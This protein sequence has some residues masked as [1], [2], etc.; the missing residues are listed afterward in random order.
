VALV[1][2]LES[3]LLDLEQVDPA[4][5]TKA[6]STLATVLIPLLAD[7]LD[8][9]WQAEAVVARTAALSLQLLPNASALAQALEEAQVNA[10]LASSQLSARTQD[11]ALGLQDAERLLVRVSEA[12]VALEAQYRG[13]AAALP[14]MQLVAQAAAE[15]QAAIASMTAG[16][17]AFVAGLAAQVAGIRSLALEQRIDAT[18]LATF[19]PRAEAVSTALQDSVVLAAELQVQARAM[20][21]TAHQL[22]L[23][24]QALETEAARLR[25]QHE[26][27]NLEHSALQM[28]AA[29]HRL[30]L[31]QLESQ[32]SAATSVVQLAADDMAQLSELQSSLRSQASAI[33]TIAT[34]SVDML[35]QEQSRLAL[36]LECQCRD[37]GWI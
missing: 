5:L 26:A 2:R 23:S 24:S 11:A 19:Q 9:A 25:Q 6:T 1:A 18:V 12:H 22:R 33:S 17:A 13:L 28:A 7:G 15:L 20:A 27:M 32:A 29:D 30:Q 34:A 35:R 8:R 37:R 4:T 10:A 31:L 36:Q 3:L 14:G 16:A 21:S